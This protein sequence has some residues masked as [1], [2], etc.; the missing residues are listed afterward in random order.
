MFRKHVITGEKILIDSDGKCYEW[1]NIWTDPGWYELPNF[2]ITN[3]W[4]KCNEQKYN[5]K[6]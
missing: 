3:D 6:L 5:K 4:K 2:C 1:K